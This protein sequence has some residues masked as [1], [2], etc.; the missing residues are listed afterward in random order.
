M[1]GFANTFEAAAAPIT[2]LLIAPL[3]E[4]WIIPLLRTEGGLRTIEREGDTTMT[5]TPSHSVDRREDRS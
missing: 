1:F 3:A 5:T 2:A 4:L